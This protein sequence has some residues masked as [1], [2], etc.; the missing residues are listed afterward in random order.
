MNGATREDRGIVRVLVREI[1]IKALAAVWLA[2]LTAVFGLGG[3][4]VFAQTPVADSHSE[5]RSVGF[6]LVREGRW[7]EADEVFEKILKKS[8]K[9]ALSLYGSALSKFN[10][11]DI[12]GAGNRVK[13]A[14]G[15]LGEFGENKALLADCLVLSAIVGARG[16]A[17]SEAVLLLKRAVELVPGHFDANF[18]FARA[19]Y[20]EGDLKNAAIYFEK[21]VDIQPQ[22]TNARFFLATVLENLGDYEGS[23]SEY[24]K[25]V[26]ASPDD[27]NGNLGLGVLLLKL[28]GDSS[29]E[30][31]RA[32]EKV[33]EKD[34]GI[35]EA[36]IELGRHQVRK[37]LFKDAI[38]NLEAAALLKPGNPEAYYQL[39]IA[40][41]RLGMKK[42]AEEAI[43]VVKSIHESRRKTKV[44]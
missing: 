23:L 35:Y 4:D 30:G 18:S 16:G 29:V 38:A 1:R 2:A 26:Q 8:G 3:Q 6:S 41:R 44:N 13:T 24:R 5:Q 17:N 19:L 22:N 42:E 25:I 7:R 15:I 40:Y 28:E 9:D 36:R 37:K 20:G 27:I 10:Y 11:G 32:L 39:A 12:T 43:Q 14:I 33:I 21:A 34:G 31:V